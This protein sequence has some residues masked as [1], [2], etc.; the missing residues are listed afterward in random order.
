MMGH[1]VGPG[2]SRFEGLILGIKTHNSMQ[3]TIM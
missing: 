1:L 2:G 3:K